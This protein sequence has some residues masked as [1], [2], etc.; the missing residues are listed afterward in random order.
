[1]SARAISAA[2]ARAILREDLLGPQADQAPVGAESLTEDA[3][4][5]R[6][7]VWALSGGTEPAHTHRVLHLALTRGPA[8]VGTTLGS[9]RATGHTGQ[10]VA[11]RRTQLKECLETLA[12]LEDLVRLAGGYWL[13][14]PLRAVFDHQR[15]DAQALLVGGAP[16]WLVRAAVPGI[17]LR[18]HETLRT[19]EPGAAAGQRL[20][21]EG[22]AAQHPL[23]DWA[24]RPEGR[25]QT[26]AEWGASVIKSVELRPVERGVGGRRV[27]YD[28]S[29]RERFQQ[30]R[31]RDPD[32]GD[33]G[34]FLAYRELEFGG[35]DYE[36]VEFDTGAVVRAAAV[37]ATAR[38][39]RLMYAIDALSENP[40]T[41]QLRHQQGG[42]AVVLRN[43]VPPAEARIF[44][45][46][47][48]LI[49]EHPDRYYP[50]TWRFDVR[51]EELIRGELAR[52]GIREEWV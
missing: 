21:S 44:A 49:Q 26:L 51:H 34:R 43:V 19:F 27:I 23:E 8:A 11:W 15:R 37:P 24:R 7:C 52:L 36:L 40:T 50:R 42:L 33:A 47:G 10:L 16:S 5:L 48:R 9:G 30:R 25:D 28:G 12:E 13:P 14:A 17:A 1:M 45:A 31:Y 3:E 18:F 20:T 4:L 46:H 38:V 35:R 32:T 29:R 6:A 2:E 41:A 39:R 22:L